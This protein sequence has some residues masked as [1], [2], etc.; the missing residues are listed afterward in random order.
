[1]QRSDDIAI[2]LRPPTRHV[3]GDEAGLAELLNP[4]APPLPIPPA[5]GWSAGDGTASEAA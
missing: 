4:V 2:L 1:M 5:D 3:T